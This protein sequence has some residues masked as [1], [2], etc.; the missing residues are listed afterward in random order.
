MSNFQQRMMCYA[1]L[2]KDFDIIIT[3]YSQIF[4]AME[5]L[6]PTILIA[7]PILYQMMHT[8]FMKQPSWKKHPAMMMGAVLSLLPS[9]T[10]RLALARLLFNSFHKQLGSRMRCVITGMAPI[11]RNVA[12]FFRRM[13]LPLAESYGLVETGSLTYRSPAS[14]Q[15][16]SVGFPLRGV[17]LLLD[18]DGEIIVQREHPLT[19]RYFQCAEGENER[20]FIGVGK[21]ATGDIGKFDADG[22][23]YLMGRKKELIITPGGYKIHPEIIEEEIN[24]CPDIA[25]SVIFLRSSAN[26]LTCVIALNE[27]GGDAAKARVRK[28]VATLTTTRKA[29]QFVE[30]VFSDTPFSKE[31]GMLRPNLKV[32]RRRV[33]ANYNIQAT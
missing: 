31:N 9:E 10:A 27:P 23:L 25:H 22:N 32:D 6:H 4:A 29:T 14:R 21:I 16:G 28:L 19:S 11:G 13:Q 3:D 17:T 2:W 12:Y 18:D 15:L 20:T 30:V 5:A 7:P 33:A 1:A 8:Q 26:H 24:R